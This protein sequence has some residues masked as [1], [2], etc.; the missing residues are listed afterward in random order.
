MKIDPTQFGNEADVLER[1]A[2]MTPQWLAGFF[3]GDGHVSICRMRSSAGARKWYL[4][5]KCTFT[6]KDALTLCVI[7]SK[8]GFPAP[9]LKEAKKYK[10]GVFEVCLQGK[11]A[12]PFLECIKDHVIIRRKQVEL[13]LEFSSFMYVGSGYKLTDEQIERAIGLRNQISE[14]NGAGRKLVE[15]EV[16][17]AR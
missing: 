1:V 4:R 15:M 6:N 8:F 12:V 5:L 9:L 13:A 2:R 7:A 11:N 17:D 10:S 14:L 3:D 16:S